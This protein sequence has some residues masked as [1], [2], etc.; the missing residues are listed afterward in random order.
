MHKL[1]L[2]KPLKKLTDLENNFKKIVGRV[3]MVVVA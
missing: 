1:Q 3:K 2:P